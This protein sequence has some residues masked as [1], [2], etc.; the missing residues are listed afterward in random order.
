[1][2]YRGVLSP[3]RDLPNRE[4]YNRIKDWTLGL[5]IEIRALYENP[6]TEPNYTHWIQ[7]ANE[8]T[9]CPVKM[10]DTRITMLQVPPL[11]DM[12][13]RKN[14]SRNLE[15]EG[16]AFLH[17]MLFGTE[18]PESDE[19]LRIPALMTSSKADQAEGNMTPVQAFLKERL[20]DCPGAAIPWAEF[21]K[22]FVPFLELAERPHWPQA[23]VRAGLPAEYPRGKY[24]TRNDTHIG[25]VKWR[26]SD[27]K[28][29]ELL[30][31][32]GERLR[33]VGQHA[34]ELKEPRGEPLTEEG[35]NA[36]AA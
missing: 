28:P 21:W 5:Q 13:S 23:R 10:G 16:P 19:R 24:G 7:C 15:V 1:M 11:T 4:A 34:T 6:R 20:E 18:I 30:Q 3:H 12:E 26:G 27:A 8:A 2:Q 17:T 25:N 31:R 9:A 36:A 22:E 29:G 14:W 33:Q 32:V 35:F